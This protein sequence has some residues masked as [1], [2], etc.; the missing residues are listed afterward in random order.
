M[1]EISAKKGNCQPKKRKLPILGNGGKKEG[2]FI[3]CFPLAF[4]ICKICVSNTPG[5]ATSHQKQRLKCRLLVED[6][7]VAQCSLCKEWFQNAKPE[8]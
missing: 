5:I 1:S 3:F 2:C 4:V 7:T 6:L 8:G